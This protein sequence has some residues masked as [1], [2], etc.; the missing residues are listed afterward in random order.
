MN[1]KLLASAALA[2]LVL[3]PN[4]FAGHQGTYL[5]VSGVA[6]QLR[7]E[8]SNEKP[9]E[10]ALS[11][12]VAVGH[13]IDLGGFFVAPELFADSIRSDVVQAGTEVEIKNRYGAKLN[14]GT[15]VQEGLDAYVSVGVSGLD[16]QIGT[17]EDIQYD[18]VYGAGVNYDLANGHTL[19]V[20]YNYQSDDLKNAAGTKFDTD[21]HLVKV[22]LVL[23]F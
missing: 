17:K 5:T 22:G 2:S 10:E 8:I 18:A 12:G 16:Y 13:S 21:L 1:K 15:Q 11:I 3:A 14:I 19:N 9:N 23:K 4:A 20:E 7:S 6:S